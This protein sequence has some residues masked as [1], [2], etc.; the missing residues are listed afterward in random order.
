MVLSSIKVD[1]C[2]KAGDLV[3]HKAVDLLT[4]RADGRPKAGDLDCHWGV[5]FEFI[6]ADTT[7][8]LGGALAGAMLSAIGL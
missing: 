3:C 4:I 8:S 5:Y 6:K 1:G 2:P 7:S